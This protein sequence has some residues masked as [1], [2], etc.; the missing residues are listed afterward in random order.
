MAASCRSKCPGTYNVTCTR[1]RVH[2][3]DHWFWWDTDA[4]PAYVWERRTLRIIHQPRTTV[5]G[6]LGRRNAEW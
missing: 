4:T 2:D 5:G 6:G 3:G 1:D